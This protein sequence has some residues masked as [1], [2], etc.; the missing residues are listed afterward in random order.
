MNFSWVS[1]SLHIHIHRQCTLE[2]RRSGNAIC[3]M[4]PD[5]FWAVWLAKLLFY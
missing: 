5:D 4:S 2:N 1:M 3:P